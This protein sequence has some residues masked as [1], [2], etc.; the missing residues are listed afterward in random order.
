MKKIV[1]RSLSMGLLLVMTVMLSSFAQAQPYIVT[2][3][4]AIDG[5][6]VPLPQ[7]KGIEDPV[8][9]LGLNSL[10]KNNVSEY[11]HQSS[12]DYEQEQVKVWSAPGS[13]YQQGPIVSFGVRISTYINK[14]AHPA[15]Q[16]LTFTVNT[17]SGQI[18]R[19][20]DLFAG[21]AYMEKLPLLLNAQLSQK[22]FKYFAAPDIKAESTNFYLTADGL[23]IYFQQSEIAAYACGLIECHLPYRDIAD[24]MAPDMLKKIKNN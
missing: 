7:I 19:L 12:Y 23:V 5:Y 2:E 20:G 22:P 16:L 10:V 21:N 15:N 3:Q 9:E 24:I 6:T 8:L 4:V 14:A 18:Y 13:M 11:I 17:E 1:V